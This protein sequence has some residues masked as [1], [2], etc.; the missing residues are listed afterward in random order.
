PPEQRSIYLIVIGWIVADS[1]PDEGESFEIKDYLRES[2]RA[3]LQDTMPL[4]AETL[5]CKHD[6]FDTC[7]LFAA[8][9]ALKGHINLARVLHRMQCICGKCPKCGER[10][11][12]P[13]LQE[14]MRVMR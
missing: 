2:Y 8:I 13:E 7:Y 1:C 4:I 11:Y 12:P 5:A 3:A 9:A 10:V 14:V 6:V